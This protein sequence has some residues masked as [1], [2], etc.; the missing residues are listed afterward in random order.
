MV[1]GKS[2]SWFTG[3]D[4]CGKSCRDIWPEIN[5]YPIQIPL[6]RLHWVNSL[7]SKLNY[8]RLNIKCGN[9][10]QDEEDLI[11]K[12]HALLGTRYLLRGIEL[13]SGG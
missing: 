11:I 6:H 5:M 9:F 12:L 7:N 3:V 8:L 1:G 4:R 13:D 2:W 10:G